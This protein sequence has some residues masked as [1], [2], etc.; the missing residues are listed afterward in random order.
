[1][2]IWLL[3]S[4]L[5]QEVAGG[6]ARYIDTF[7]RLLGAAGHEVVIIARTEHGCDQEIAPGVRVIGVVPD[8]LRLNEANPGEHPSTHPAYPYNF[9]SYWPAFSYQMAEVVLQLATRLPLPDIIESQEYGAVPY[10][11][12]QRKYIERTPLEHTPILVHLHS[13]V[14][15]LETVNQH[16]RYRFPEYWIGQMEKFSILAADA[17]LSPSDFLARRVQHA[18]EHTVAI[19]RI[20][21]PLATVPAMS[22][23]NVQRKKIVYVGRLELRKGVFPLVKAC[24]RLWAAGEDFQ[25]VMIGGDTDFVPRATKCG[26]FLRQRYAKWIESGHLQLAGQLGREALLTQVQ[27]AW[28]VVVPSIWENFPNTCMEAMG[29]GQV[30]LASRAGGQAEMLEADGEAGF[31][32]DWEHA[33]EFEQKLRT[34]LALHESERSTIARRAHERIA[35]FC[36]PTTICQQRVQHYE[37]IIANTSTRT[38]FPTVNRIENKLNISAMTEVNG[39]HRPVLLSVIIPFYNLG[40]YVRETV[41]NVRAANY[42]PIEILIVNDGSSDPK[43]LEVLHD[44]E[45]QGLPNVRILHTE[46][47]GLAATRNYGAEA[48]RGEFL[49]FVDADDLVEPDFFSRAI[50]ILHRYTNVTFVYSWVQ[51]VGDSN[52]IWPTWNTE[53]PYLLG[54]NMLTAFVVMRR[55]AFLAWVRNQPIFEYGLEDYDGWIGLVEAGGVGVSIPQPL[56]RYRIRRQSMYQSSNRNQQLYLF[57]LLTQRHTESYHRWGAELFNLLNANG[58]SYLWNNPAISTAEVP[59]ASIAALEQQRDRLVAEVQTLG[60]AWED[61]VRFIAAQRAYIEDLEARCRELMPR[62]YSNGAS[63]LAATNGIPVGD[64]ELGGRLVNRVRRSWFARAVLRSP[65]LKKVLRTALRR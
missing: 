10:Y 26:A 2:K 45:Q 57:D 23:G 5:P 36:D 54:H 51:Y 18:L 42:T 52:G 1:M 14:F 46:N 17:V 19:T 44:I 55:D 15:E 12:L 38:T 60:K 3:T 49:T 32:F 27:Q 6:I 61:H 22:L 33:G 48:A 13:P 50:D 29:V 25:L 9:M 65:T 34:I 64:Y 16:A 62:V 7:A 40:D 41:E 63:A 21:Y 58:P 43:S 31:L 11:L 20:P 37:A 47:Q 4:E 8:Y 56:V 30:V 53:F 24:S 35:T 39:T 28:A 59:T